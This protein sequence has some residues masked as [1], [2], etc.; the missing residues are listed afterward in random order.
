MAHAHEPTGVFDKIVVSS[1][2]EFSG[3]GDFT[4]LEVTYVPS[5]LRLHQLAFHHPPGT[6]PPTKRNGIVSA[7]YIGDD[8]FLLWRQ[9][10]GMAP[11]RSI[12]DSAPHG[13]VNAGQ[14]DATWIK[15]R[16]PG[17]V[18]PPNS[19]KAD[20]VHFRLGWM[21][22]SSEGVGPGW[23]LATDCLPLEELVQ[24]VSSLK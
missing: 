14:F 13:T 7:Y 17:G 9:G 23:L 24:I 20:D 8:G 2:S 6:K 11:P 15:G 16:E 10:W 21:P 19:T 22:D 3:L 12:P 18:G 1:W 5:G 4:P